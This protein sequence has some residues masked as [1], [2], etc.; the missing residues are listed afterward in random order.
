MYFKNKGSSHTYH[1]TCTYL[2]Y[3]TYDTWP[4]KI[5]TWY[6]IRQLCQWH[7]PHNTDKYN[8]ESTRIHVRFEHF[9]KCMIKVCLHN[10]SRKHFQRN[11]T[12][13]HHVHSYI[14]ADQVLYNYISN[15]LGLQTLINLM[16]KI[17]YEITLFTLPFIILQ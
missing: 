11:F 12:Q 14:S 10:N 1:I 15:K 4:L 3:V 16:Q 7:Y 17:I 8:P 5:I 13:L 2:A 6:Q 9:N